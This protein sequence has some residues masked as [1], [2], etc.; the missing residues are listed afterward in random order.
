MSSGSSAN[1]PVPH[2]YRASAEDFRKIPGSPI[3][4]WVSE[5]LLSSFKLKKIGWF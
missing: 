4:Y 1:N 5:K 3:A 2:F